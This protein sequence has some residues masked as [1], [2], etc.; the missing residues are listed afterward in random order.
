MIDKLFSTKVK[1]T[2]TN[3]VL[4]EYYTQWVKTL[5]FDLKTK[6]EYDYYYNEFRR[7]MDSD[8]AKTELG[9]A[10]EKML[11]LYIQSSFLPK[12]HRMMRYVRSAVRAFYSCTSC[13]AEHANRSLNASVGT[14]PQQ[15]MHR[16]VMVMV[17]KEEH[18]YQVN[19]SVSGRAIV[20]TQL[21]S[22]E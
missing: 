2:D 12:E 13:Q 7:F 5:C 16:S 15:N 21:C 10:R 22:L 8:R 3:I 11:D 18:R 4:V 17:N 9:H 14:K 6:E 19:A 1:I 20:E